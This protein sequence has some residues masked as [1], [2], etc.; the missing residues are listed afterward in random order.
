L[1]TN[2][3]KHRSGDYVPVNAFRLGWEPRWDSEAKL[4]DSIDDE[5]TAAQ[6]VRPIKSSIYDALHSKQLEK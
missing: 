2:A 3:N 4:L 5:I 6:E 1:T